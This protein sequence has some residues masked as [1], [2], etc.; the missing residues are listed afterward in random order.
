MDF[1]NFGREFGKMFPGFGGKISIGGGDDEGSSGRGGRGYG[2]GHVQ[3]QRPRVMRVVGRPSRKEKKNPFSGVLTQRFEEIK[4]KCL[5]EGVLFEDPE[6]PAED[7]S[8]FF[9]KS[10]PR[11]FEW[12]RPTVSNKIQDTR[13]FICNQAP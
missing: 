3:T 7:G 4:K 6:F 13:Y 1:G 10:P 5:E 12:K 2:G 9:S 11:P 8:I